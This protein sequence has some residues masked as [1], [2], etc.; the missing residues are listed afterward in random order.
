MLFRSQCLRTLGDVL[1]GQ[2]KYAEASPVLKAA[3]AEY[4][5]LGEPFGVAEC[6][7]SLGIVLL[8]QERYSEASSTLAE[9]LHQFQNIGDRY[10]EAVCLKF[11]SMLLLGEGKRTEGGNSLT[12]ARNL[13]LDIRLENQARHCSG[14]LETLGGLEDAD[15][16]SIRNIFRDFRISL[17]QGSYHVQ[18]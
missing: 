17:I 9:A 5:K 16:G 18:L 2:G 11:L 10:G 8:S 12:R 4:L 1:I 6:A 13:Y 14:W 7:R 3:H 15:S